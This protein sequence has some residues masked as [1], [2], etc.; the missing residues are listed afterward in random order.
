MGRTAAAKPP[1]QQARLHQCSADT[2][3]APRTSPVSAGLER[4]WLERICPL[5]PAAVICRSQPPAR[6]S[7]ARCSRLVRFHELGGCGGSRI[8]I[9]CTCT[10][11]RLLGLR[12]THT[13]SD[14]RLCTSPTGWTHRG[15]SA[16]HP[17]GSPTHIPVP[18]LWPEQRNWRR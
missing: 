17:R 11:V 10:I 18:S 8:R 1:G 9:S 3:P 5:L 7:A 2:H 6:N 12:V 15:C 16:P 4:T 14:S 13:Q